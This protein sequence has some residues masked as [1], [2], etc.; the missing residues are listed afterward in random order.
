MDVLQH[1]VSITKIR[2]KEWNTFAKQASTLY[3]VNK[4][5]CGSEINYS[6]P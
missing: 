3:Y 5:L 4:I 6:C 1:T 2:Y